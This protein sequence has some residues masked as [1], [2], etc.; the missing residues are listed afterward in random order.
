LKKS[1]FDQYTMKKLLYL[2]FFCFCSFQL[3]AQTTNPQLIT[4]LPSVLN[5]SS[6]VEVNGCNSIWTHNDSGDSARIFNI[7]TLGNILR[8]LHLSIDTAFDCEESTQDSEGNFYI[9]DFGNNLQNRTNLR[10][11]KIPN[12][13]SLISDTVFPEIINFSFSDQVLFPPPSAAQNFDCEAMF[14]FNDSLYLFSKNW[15]TSNYSKMYR[16]PDQPGDYVAELLDSFNTGTWVTSADISPTGKTMILLSET[17]IWLF[18]EYTPGHF[19][20]GYAQQLTM[21]YSQKEAVVFVDDSVVYITDEFFLS[22]GGNLYSLNLASWINALPDAIKQNEIDI[23]P[24]P[25]INQLNIQFNNIPGEFTT[26]IFNI[27][28]YLICHENN[29]S[30][31]NISDLEPGIYLLKIVTYEKA[32]FV[33]FIKS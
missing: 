10:I 16:L 17:R 24:N 5:E 26:E 8:I 21:D 22:V 15:G 29:N 18:T 12:P 28:G 20:D 27:S 2:L 7:D 6:G 32:V 1:V 33:K 4:P 13:D 14:H 31:L 3:K 9:G 25:A 30:T 23:Y 19:F 11:Y